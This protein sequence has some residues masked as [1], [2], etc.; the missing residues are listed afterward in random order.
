[1]KNRSLKFRNA[2][3][4]AELIIAVAIV[5]VTLAGTAYIF[6]ISLDAQRTATA[7]AEIMRNL[8]AITDQLNA[9]FKGL[10][11]D[12]PI[13]I[14][15]RQCS[16][17][18]NDRF[19]QIMFFSNGDFNTY[20]EWPRSNDYCESGTLKPGDPKILRSNMARVYYGQARSCPPQAS[21]AKDPCDVDATKRVL[22][23]K[24]YVM[25]QYPVL[26]KWPDPNNNYAQFQA[27]LQK[28][29]S[30]PNDPNAGNYKKREFC[31]FD[32]M[33]IN[34]WKAIP[35][36]NIQQDLIPLTFDERIRVDVNDYETYHNLLCKGV[37]GFRIQWPVWDNTKK[38]WRWGPSGDRDED[39][40]F[41]TDS[42]FKP[43]MEFG[44]IFNMKN[45]S[46]TLTPPYNYSVSAKGNVNWYPLA[47]IAN[48][49]A[50]GST[51]TKG[52]ELPRALKFTIRLCDSKGIIQETDRSGKKRKGKIFTHIIY[53]DK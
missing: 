53:L 5:T 40:N 20:Y 33:L 12:A 27:S 52:R 26:A 44:C 38:I 47:N 11:K 4:L 48:A 28:D 39:G 37:I 45:V 10:R 23:R 32:K 3:T 24:Q 35:Q 30:D 29:H 18:A 41:S 25:T 17:D 15:F 46:N 19:D 9:D 51:P 7:T 2:F 6:K 34:E 22:A 8:R 50:P 1:V 43:D 49:W 14:S 31:E 42:D 36:T 16:D 13:M 21:R